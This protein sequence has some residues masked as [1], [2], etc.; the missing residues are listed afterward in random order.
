VLKLRHAHREHNRDLLFQATEGNVTDADCRPPQLRHQ[1]SKVPAR[2]YGA[3]ALWHLEHH[4]L[5]ADEL[6]SSIELAAHAL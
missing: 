5:R 6:Y 1:T 2:S 3:L 4:C